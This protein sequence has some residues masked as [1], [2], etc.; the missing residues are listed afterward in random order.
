[1]TKSWFFQ[2]KGKTHGP[3]SSRELLNLAC[4]GHIGPQDLI[5]PEGK[6][7]QDALPADV[8]LD[9]S[10]MVISGFPGVTTSRPQNRLPDWLEDVKRLERIGP[11]PAPGPSEEKPEWL[12]DLRLWFGLDLYV[13]VKR[14]SRKTVP[15]A[16]PAGPTALGGKGGVPDWLES[17]MGFEKPKTHPPKPSPASVPTP[18]VQPAKSVAILP[19]ASPAPPSPP[20]PG[21]PAAAEPSPGPAPPAARVPDA[22]VMAVAQPITPAPALPPAPPVA[23]PLAMPVELASGEPPVAASPV[24]VPTPVSSPPVAPPA[25]APVPPD[26]SPP[27]GH[28]PPRRTG[29]PNVRPKTRIATPFGELL[30]VP[31]ETEPAIAEAAELLAENTLLETGFDL[32]T[33]Q[34]LD[35]AKFEQW[36]Q[37]QAWSP[38]ADQAPVTNASLFEIFRKARNAIANWVDDE[39]NR[40]LVLGSG[41]EEILAHPA[42]RALLDEY[43][44]HSDE[45]EGKL[46]QHLEFV[47]EN[48]RKYY[49][50]VGN[51]QP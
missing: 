47:V 4:K 39:A 3:V 32:K 10:K 1:M 35:A 27:A 46:V 49:Q 50:A 28:R 37:Q 33:G 6:G 5:W 20:V 31:G 15:R 24:P 42:V 40:S 44:R 18:T 45:M 12:E 51:N 43:A 30:E 8:A 41:M 23:V 29:L 36:K 7:L 48:R 11:H 26:Q 38:G 16:G 25:A 9:F 21:P 19:V 2:H 14:A 13:T 34:I 22:L 17:W